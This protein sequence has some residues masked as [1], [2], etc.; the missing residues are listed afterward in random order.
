MRRN[1]SLIL[2]LLLSAMIFILTACSGSHANSN[3]SG[4]NREN[5]KITVVSTIFPIYDWTENVLGKDNSLEFCNHRLMLDGSTDIHSF[6][7]TVSDVAMISSCDLFI[8]VGG[9]SEAWVDDVLSQAKNPNMKVIRLMDYLKENMLV[10]EEIEGAAGNHDHE[11]NQEQHEEEPEYDEHIWLSL[12]N[13][14]VCVRTINNALCE[15][16]PDRALSFNNNADKY[17]LK[18]K[19][20]DDEYSASVSEAKK[21]TILVADR[22]PFRY[23]V[24]DYN[25]N[26]Y[27]AFSGCSTESE[28][29]FETIKF[30]ISKIDELELPVI[31]VLE[32]TD[33]KLADTISK[34]SKLKNQQI[35]RLDSLQSVSTKDENADYLELM[36][37]NLEVLRIAMN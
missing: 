37:N 26:Y 13:A 33:T 19:A 11:G 16:L 1:K 20:L 21:D 29:D 22:F 2:P 3:L 14:E 32:N 8:Y 27:A 36:E 15:L 23:L 24:E 25:I 28:A 17:I 31:F 18:I 30:L 9:E 10:E 12:K 5:N 34:S 6:E 35:L 4:S 7:P